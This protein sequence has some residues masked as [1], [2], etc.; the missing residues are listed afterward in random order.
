VGRRRE[1]FGD[2]IQSQDG[3]VCQWHDVDEGE[4]D[5]PGYVYGWEE[6][7]QTVHEHTD[8]KSRY[9][10]KHCHT[11]T[12]ERWFSECPNLNCG[13]EGVMREELGWEPND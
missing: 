11:A 1:R 10:C 5:D 6:T 12:H 9:R 3:S 13:F 7:C 2:A 8:G 4:H